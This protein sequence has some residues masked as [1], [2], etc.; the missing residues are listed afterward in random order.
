MCQKYRLSTTH[1]LMLSFLVFILIGTCLL[2]LPIASSTGVSVGLVNALFT[3]TTSSCV[4]GLVVIPTVSSWSMFGQVVILILIQ[5]GGLGVITAMTGIAIMLDKRLGIANGLLLQ[6]TLNLT[7]M[8]GLVTFIKKVINGTF[9]V[10]GIGAL[11]YMLVFI[12]EFGARG[13][14]ISIFNSVSA[15]CNA[16]IDIISENSL[17]DY[18]TNPMINFTTCMLIVLGGIGYVVWW[19]LLKI[20]KN[21]HKQKMK[22]RNLTLHSKIV[23]SATGFLIAFGAI[24]IFVFE[25]N[26]PMT[27]QNLS[28]FDKIQASIFQSV[29]L[30]TA[31]FTTINQEYLT[32]SSVMLSLL[33]MF[34]GGSPVGTAGGVKT[35]T[36]VVL[37]ASAL[38][39]IRNENRVNLFDRAIS[40]EVIKKSIAV[41]CMSF[42]IAFISTMLLS[43]CT[44]TDFIKIIYE[45]ISASA[46][47]GLSMN[48]TSSLNTIGKII[49]IVTMYFGRVGPISLAI[50]FNI[51][52]ENKNIVKNPIEEISVG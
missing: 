49:I 19:D 14:W 2:S 36:M 21:R 34:I 52:S 4:T 30:R 18:A 48:L 15:F 12:P 3:A 35:I 31:G 29:T 38:A 28:L 39:T 33:L 44:Q 9:I 6:D 17:C 1:I 43:I 22:F 11:L 13:I 10:E 16:G 7:T 51:K 24:L 42:I 40:K 8:S 46:T 50:A 37:F 47:V 5:V 41:V 26:N 20:F 45:V 23:L 27:M 32:N 25:Y